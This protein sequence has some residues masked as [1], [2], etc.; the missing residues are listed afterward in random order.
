[1][2]GQKIEIMYE[3]Y[4]K[5]VLA[6]VLLSLWAACCD[7]LRIHKKVIIKNIKELTLKFVNKYSRPN[8]QLISKKGLC[9]TCTKKITETTFAK[10]KYNLKDFWIWWIFSTVRRELT[11]QCKDCVWGVSLL[12]IPKFN[13]KKEYRDR[14]ED[15]ESEISFE[16]ET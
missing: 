15:W 3:Y 9:I 7:P 6:Q 1:M 16:K 10:K 12:K 4:E 13:Q 14:K 5:K 2:N 8:F 11:K